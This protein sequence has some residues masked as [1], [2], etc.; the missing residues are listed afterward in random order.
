M[1]K[2]VWKTA[3]LG[4]KR[5]F[6][7]G[8]EQMMIFKWDRSWTASWE[9]NTNFHLHQTVPQRNF[10]QNY[11]MLEMPRERNRFCSCR[12]CGERRDKASEKKKE[13]HGQ[14]EWGLGSFTALVL[15]SLAKLS[16]PRAP[17]GENQ[18][19]LRLHHYLHIH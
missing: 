7:S 15:G 19:S 16:F 6:S 2:M 4:E 3:S 13:L 17:L 11:R 9:G 10:E 5:A 18:D 12:G 1:Y 14:H 8:P